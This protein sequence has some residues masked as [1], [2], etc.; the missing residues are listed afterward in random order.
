MTAMRSR[1]ENW[2]E[3]DTASAQVTAQDDRYLASHRV[4]IDR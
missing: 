3:I 4:F 2:T 1:P